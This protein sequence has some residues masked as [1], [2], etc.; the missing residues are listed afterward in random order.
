[1]A[2]TVTAYHGTADEIKEFSHNF[3]GQNTCNN[4]GGFY[5][6]SDK[7]VAFDY[8]RDSYYRRHEVT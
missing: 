5:F 4:A 3:M 8:S 6:T 2:L 7:D 1:M